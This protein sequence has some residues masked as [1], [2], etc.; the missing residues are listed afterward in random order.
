MAPLWLSTTRI[1]IHVGKSVFYRT[2]T[3]RVCGWSK[4][5]VVGVRAYSETSKSD[6][7]S[8]KPKPDVPAKNNWSSTPVK[9]SEYV[10]QAEYNRVSYEYPE[11]PKEAKF[12]PVES[13]P[14]Q[15]HI[16]LLAGLAGVLWAIYAYRH[17]MSEKKS[18][19]QNV[20]SPDHF[21]TYKLTYKEDISPDVALLELSPKYDTHRELIKKKGGLWNGKKIWSVEVKQP[22]IQ[23]VR[24]YT[25]LPMYYM[26]YKEGDETKG[27]LRLLGKDDDEGR[28]VMLVKK[29]SDGEVSR[30]LHKLPLG[31]DVEIR[32]PHIGYKFPYSPI[33]ATEPRNPMLDLPSR[34][35]PEYDHPEGVPLP[36]NVAFF[37]GGTGISAILQSLFSV[38]P[39]RGFTTVYYSVRSR[40][41][42]PFQRFLLF[43]EKVGRAK[44]NIFVDNENK[45]V[46]LKDV[47]EP[48]EL[49]YSSAQANAEVHDQIE[50]EV[51]IQKMMEAMRKEKELGI[52]AKPSLV[53]I[54]N[55]VSEQKLANVSGEKDTVASNKASPTKDVSPQNPKLRYNSILEQVADNPPVPEKPSLAVVCG[56]EGYVN[57]IAGSMGPNG[58]APIGGLLGRRGWNSQNT[59]RMEP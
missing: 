58:D 30:Y 50:Q 23:V 44:F 24:K 40:D 33:D 4:I 3:P 39:P 6:E 35:A 18:G 37:A 26:Q 28:F 41:E 19:D 2:S 13:K 34:M 15:R 17:F 55:Q 29:Y 5:T 59:F 47:P 48:A 57:F 51:K 8:S 49:N 52:E 22:E 36:E 27:L 10:P 54:S 38:N 53:E 1:S 46:S 7:S 45:F 42:I 16:P 32:G 14:F 21:V 20:L 11:P 56:P 25:P 9:K 31:S 12:I 43:L